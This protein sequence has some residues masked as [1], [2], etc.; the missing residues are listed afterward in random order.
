MGTGSSPAAASARPRPH[1]QP[2]PSLTPRSGLDSNAELFSTSASRQVESSRLGLRPTTTGARN[3]YALA[4]N[5]NRLEFPRLGLRSTTTGLRSLYALTLSPDLLEFPHL[6]LRLITTSSRNLYALTLNP[7][8]LEFSRLG[9]RPTMTG[10]RHLY[11]LALSPNMLEFSRLGHRQNTIGSRNLYA[12]A[13]SP[14]RL[15]STRLG[16]RPTTTGPRHLHALAFSSDKARITSPMDIVR[17]Q[18]A[19]QSSC[20]SHRLDERNS[21][22][23]T[24]PLTGS[25]ILALSLHP[26]GSSDLALDN[27]TAYGLEYPLPFT[28]S[29]LAQ[30]MKLASDDD[31]AYGLKYPHPLTPSYRLEQTRFGRHCLRA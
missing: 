23:T 26:I 9:L 31:T 12:L 5:P 29:L 19:R 15:E 16:L 27:D 4:F 21:P 17:R 14:D 7:D 11:A 1:H 18:W 24:T 28:L 13:F 25:S 22:R 8:R 6:G 3:L 30:G 20:C 2:I 10:S